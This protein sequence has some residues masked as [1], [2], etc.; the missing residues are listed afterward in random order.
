MG[1]LDIVA[2]VLLGKMLYRD[3]E[4]SPCGDRSVRTV[5]AS[6]VCCAAFTCIVA[7]GYSLDFAAGLVDLAVLLC[8]AAL[9]F[10][11]RFF[12]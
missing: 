1:L 11:W 3:M 10:L 5:A 12:D 8:A 2:C 7:D 4:L 9:R 6:A